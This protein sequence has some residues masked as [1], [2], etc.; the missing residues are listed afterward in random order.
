MAMPGWSSASSL[1]LLVLPGLLASAGCGLRS[2]PFAP[3]VASEESGGEE[4]EEGEESGGDPFRPG[5]CNDPLAMPFS[6]MT[7]RGELSGPSFSEGWCGSD[8]GPE[9]VYT[10]VPDYDVDVILA[11]V[12]A[13]TEF[14]PT[15][16]VVEDGCTPGTGI[17]QV[18]TRS[19]DEQPYHFLARAGHTYS[20]FIDTA[21]GGAG[22]YA[23]EVGFGWPSLDLC[24][25]HPEVIQQIPGSA[26]IWN[27]DFS[28]GQGRVDGYCGGPGRENMFPL[29]ATYSG[30]VY[31][32]VETS[33]AFAPVIS[34]RTDCAALSELACSADVP[35]GIADLAYT[36]VEPGQYYLVVDQAQIGAGGY[37]LRV[38]FD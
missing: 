19:F 3:A 37:S 38:D 35:G 6:P 7:L 11:L 22:K 14:T 23:F 31:A 26:F 29:L 1:L 30:N 27:N 28:E 4:S 13:E 9:D 12:N 24:D 10:L 15:L 2:D 8:G 16:R 5:T 20:I 18:C 32:H 33:G 21:D 34:L 36:I 17:T 25:P